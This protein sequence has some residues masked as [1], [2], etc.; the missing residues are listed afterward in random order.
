M[1]EQLVA[2][3]LDEHPEGGKGHLSGT[4]HGRET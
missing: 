1:R 3:A 4:G 2:M